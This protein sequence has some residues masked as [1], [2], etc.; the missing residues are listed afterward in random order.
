MHFEFLLQANFIISFYITVT[1]FVTSIIY[2]LFGNHTF[3]TLLVVCTNELHFN[4]H[5]TLV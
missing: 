3:V 2:S 1:L 5:V 4:G